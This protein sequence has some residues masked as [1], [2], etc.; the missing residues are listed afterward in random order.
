MGIDGRAEGRLLVESLKPLAGYW[1]GRQKIQEMK[2][3]GCPHWRQMEWFG[4]YFEWQGK[5]LLTSKNGG[6]DGPRYGRTAIDYKLSYPWDLKMHSIPPRPSI[7]SLNDVLAVD[8]AIDEYGGVGFLIGCGHPELDAGGEFRDWH[9]TYSG[10]PSDYS[11]KRKAEGSPSRTR[12]SGFLLRYV[13][14]FFLSS[15]DEVRR[16]IGEGW[17]TNRNQ[18]GMRN[19]NDAIRNAKYG[20]VVEKIPTWARV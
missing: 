6:S 7:A 2:K 19:S 1:N 3:G 20:V 11:L 15:H 14:G 5:E 16:A 4:F 18:A 10:G 9:V 12:K 8:R 13:V 17:L